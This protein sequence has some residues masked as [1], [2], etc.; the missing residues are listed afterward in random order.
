VA[1]EASTDT[2]PTY[3]H[4][5]A[6]SG[7]VASPL[8][9]SLETAWETQLDDGRLGSPVVTEDQVFLPAID[10]HRLVALDLASGQVLWK[11]TAGGRIDSP[12]TIHGQTAIF[13]SADGWIYCVRTTDGQLVWRFRAAPEDR[14]I[15]VH[16]QL[17]SVWPLHGSVLVQDGT[18][19]A[20]AGRTGHLD[21]GM[22]LVRLE[23]AS[24]KLRSETP[25]TDAAL[26]DVRVSPASKVRSARPTATG[27][28]AAPVQPR[29]LP[30][31]FLVAPHLLAVRHTDALGVGQLAERG[32]PGSRRT[33]AG[34]E[35]GS[36]VRFWPIRPVS[37]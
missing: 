10:A 30:G 19:F 23:A 35:H 2:W 31:R 14:R 20:V 32:H 27:R 24:G 29:R 5:A 13:G 9:D 12:P 11:F 6:R 17:E 33:P 18:V 15:V 22:L 16:D 37:P 1:P 36:G 25:L 28:R 26:P 21:G 3:R 34:A 7:C 8:P 4:D